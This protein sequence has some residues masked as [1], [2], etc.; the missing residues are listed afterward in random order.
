MPC[1]EPSITRRKA[2]SYNHTHMHTLCTVQ[3]DGLFKSTP[4]SLIESLFQSDHAGFHS[5]VTENC[6]TKYCID[7][8]GDND[9]IDLCT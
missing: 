5:H 2:K 8:L 7:S 3:C 9:G 6:S 1:W 4:L